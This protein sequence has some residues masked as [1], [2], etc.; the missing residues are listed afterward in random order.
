MWRACS[1]Q[2]CGPRT[3]LWPTQRT[4]RPT[5]MTLV[6]GLDS[7]SLR[8][9]RL[10]LRSAK[11]ADRGLRRRCPLAPSTPSTRGVAPWT[12][13]S[14]SASSSW[15]SVSCRSP[16]E[17]SRTA[18]VRGHDDTS[19]AAASTPRHRI[20]RPVTGRDRGSPSRSRSNCHQRLVV[21]DLLAGD[22]RCSRRR[23]ADHADAHPGEPLTDARSV[24]LECDKDLP[25][26]CATFR[27]F[28]ATPAAGLTAG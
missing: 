23:H 5:V 16:I 7:A 27:P 8:R 9:P 18:C 12:G 1:A 13:S 11:P 3:G 14:G 24:R 15:S 4:T 21:M 2:A 28:S 19:R 20:G 22:C 26:R 10:R 25:G 6:V 17:A